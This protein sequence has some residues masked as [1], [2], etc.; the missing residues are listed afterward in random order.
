MNQLQQ[1]EAYNELEKFD[2]EFWNLMND[3]ANARTDEDLVNLKSRQDSLQTW[4]TSSLELKN[5]GI[6]MDSFFQSKE[7][8]D[9]DTKSNLILDFLNM[10][11]KKFVNFS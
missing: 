10:A 4:I 2:D 9:F 5:A 1:Y 8:M 3:R 11:L 7:A 6:V